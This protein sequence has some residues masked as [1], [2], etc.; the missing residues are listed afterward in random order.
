MSWTYKE[1]EELFQ[2]AVHL[3]KEEFLSEELL[4]ETDGKDSTYTNLDQQFKTYMFDLL[5]GQGI[6]IKKIH[7]LKNRFKMQYWWNGSRQDDLNK[8]VVLCCCIDQRIKLVDQYNNKFEQREEFTDNKNQ[9]IKFIACTIFYQKLEK[10]NR[11]AIQASLDH[12]TS[13]IDG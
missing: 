1:F 13:L 4:I 7:E 12:D 3:K 10:S 6:N 2:Q 8:V 9:W 11:Y 5:D